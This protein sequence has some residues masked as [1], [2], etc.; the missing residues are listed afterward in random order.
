[1][2]NFA[3]YAVLSKNTYVVYYIYDVDGRPIIS[4]YSFERFNILDID[5]IRNPDFQ[6]EAWVPIEPNE[7]N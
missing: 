6:C 2:N 5:K 3:H 4:F 7:E 1:M